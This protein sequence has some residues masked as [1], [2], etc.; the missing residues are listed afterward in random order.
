LEPRP[1]ICAST[2]SASAS[3][4]FALHARLVDARI[5][6]RDRTRRVLLG[7]ARAHTRR[8]LSDPLDL[9]V[10]L[11]GHRLDLIGG[12]IAGHDEDRVVGGVEAAVEGERLV[13][14]ELLDLVM[15]ADD[16]T[17]VG[18]VEI[19]RGFHLLIQPGAGIV[20]NPHIV[21]FEYDVAFRLHHVV[22]E[23]QSRHTVGL[24]FHQRLQLLARRALEVAGIVA[25]RERVLLPADGSDDLREQPLR[26]L[27]GAL[28]HQMFEEMG[29]ARFAGR[30]VGGANPVPDH[31]GD[32]GRAVV[33]DDDDFEPVSEREMGD[34]GPG[35]RRG[36][37][38]PCERQSGGRKNETSQVMRHERASRL[39]RPVIGPG[40]ATR[41]RK[42]P[43][44][45]L[46]AVDQFPS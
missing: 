44:P 32:D 2:S 18:V 14:I 43:A 40:T 36:R 28:E 11:F 13:A 23:H 8:D 10:S 7:L 3:P 5:G 45:G 37:R 22:G 34:V 42:Q 6:Q 12:D 29:E 9:A 41:R 30:F 21:F 38:Q 16:G 25:R 24:E 4:G 15:P 39:Y 31:V 26:V 46:A 17:A 19:E 35:R 20:G 33:G 1:R 27:L